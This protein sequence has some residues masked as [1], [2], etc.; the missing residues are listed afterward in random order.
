MWDPEMCN[1]SKSN[2]IEGLAEG[3]GLVFCRSQ[4]VVQCTSDLPILL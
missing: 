1:V 3:A 2:L 4:L